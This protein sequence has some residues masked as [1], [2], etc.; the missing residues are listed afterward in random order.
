MNNKIEE[1]FNWWNKFSNKDIRI[2]SK[3]KDLY[4]GL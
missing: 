4:L 2:I 1:I 3:T